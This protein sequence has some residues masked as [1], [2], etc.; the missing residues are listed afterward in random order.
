MKTSLPQL[1]LRSRLLLLVL[2]AVAPA[3][4]LIVFS[5]WG[6]RSAADTTARSQTQQVALIVAAEQ[7][8]LIEQGRLLLTML[9]SVPVVRDAD[10]LPRCSET[11]ARIRQQ[12]PIYGN[13]GVVD[14][15]GTVICSA[16][17]FKPGVNTA[18]RPWFS[19]AVASRAFAVGDYLIGRLSGRPSLTLGLPVVDDGGRLQGVVF[20]AIDLSWLQALL[21]K[22]PLPAGTAVAVVDASGTILARH[23]DPQHAWTGQ[24]APEKNELATLIGPDCRGFAEFRGL[25]N[26]LRLNAIEPLQHV[27]GKCVYVRVGVPRSEIYRPIEQRLWR[28][29]AAMA[30]VTLLAFAAAWFGSEL[31][32]LRPVRVL[33]RAAER[34]GSGDLSTRTGLPHDQE[35]LGQLARGFDEMAAGIEERENRLVETDRALQRTNRALTVLS[36]SN[37]AMLRTRDEPSLLEEMCRIVVERG[38]YPMAWVGY[39][40]E[41]DSKAIR[42]VAHH[43]VDIGQIDPR[44]LSWDE[45]VGGVTAS[46]KA[47]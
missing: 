21:E 19:R 3:F 8:R 29:L 38:A 12:N 14:A 47:I 23:P 27:D 41:G 11:L 45:T 15:A 4:G 17:P 32:I 1:S 33:G 9:S 25:D 39:L 35:E 28:H 36:A 13:I 34:L 10:M 31:L 30:L 18:D 16:L 5:T 20:A 43:G 24:P 6:E 40:D 7:N 46:G 2:L 42:P 22:L 26:V 37:R 44:C